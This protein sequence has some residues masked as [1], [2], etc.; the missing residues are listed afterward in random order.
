MTGFEAQADEEFAELE[1]R[2]LHASCVSD[3]P[4]RLQVR[5]AKHSFGTDPCDD[6]M[7]CW[8]RLRKLQVSENNDTRQIYSPMAN[9]RAHK[10]SGVNFLT[11]LDVVLPLYSPGLVKTTLERQLPPSL[12]RCFSGTKKTNLWNP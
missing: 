4:Y 7:S 1:A 9:V 11:W 5:N 8:L 6:H 10:N 3:L 12:A 2:G